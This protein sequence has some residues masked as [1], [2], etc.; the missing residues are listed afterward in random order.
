MRPD[1]T[2][3]PALRGG[4]ALLERSVTY[5]LGVL[6]PIGPGDL[7][8]PTPCARWDL[9]QLLAHVGDSMAALNEAADTG[10]VALKP[11]AAYSLAD[12]VGA[13]R[14]RARRLLGA[15]AA[16]RRRELVT[17]GRLPL[18]AAVVTCTGALELAVH[19]WD[20]ARASGQP[21]PV[22]AALAEELL[23]LAPL[24]VAAEDRPVRFAEVRWV[25]EEAGPGERLV[26]YLGRRPDWA[27]WAG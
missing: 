27:G 11:Q 15:W 26:A 20:L 9:G 1:G 22:P 2:A 7:R 14:D 4:V 5:A 23:E 13:V 18:A 6:H 12:P 3:P 17:V 24:F 21:E 19:G 25:R 16:V 10:H 8:R